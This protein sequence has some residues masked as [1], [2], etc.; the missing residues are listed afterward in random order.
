M[1]PWFEQTEK[2]NA[3]QPTVQ[4]QTENNQHTVTTLEKVSIKNTPWDIVSPEKESQNLV[5]P[6]KKSTTKFSRVAE[7]KNRFAE[8][9]K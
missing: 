9:G 1:L 5:T 8:A 3:S 4:P 6:R 2:A 7:E